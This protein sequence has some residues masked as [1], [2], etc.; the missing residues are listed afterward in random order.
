MMAPVL[1]CANHSDIPSVK[2]SLFNILPP[3]LQ[4][5]YIWYCKSFQICITFTKILCFCS[6]Y[7]PSK[8]HCRHRNFQNFE[9]VY[10]TSLLPPPIKNFFLPSEA[11]QMVVIFPCWGRQST[12]PSLIF[13]FLL[14][15]CFA[16]ISIC[17]W[18]GLLSRFPL[19]LSTVFTPKQCGVMTHQHI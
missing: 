15:H 3:S 8:V 11:R 7:F 10:F 9:F 6:K 13:I 19:P 14:Q 5:A 17:L 2:V 1:D 18:Q 4:Q 16:L 12:N